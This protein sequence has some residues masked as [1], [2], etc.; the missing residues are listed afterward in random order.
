MGMG[1]WG[2]GPAGYTGLQAA[3]ASICGCEGGDTLR[4]RLEKGNNN[5]LC[6]QKLR[7]LCLEGGSLERVLMSVVLSVLL[8]SWVSAIRS[9]FGASAPTVGKSGAAL[10]KKYA[11]VEGN[12]GNCTGNQKRGTWS[13]LIPILQGSRERRG[14]SWWHFNCEKPA[15]CAPG[16]DPPLAP[17]SLLL[18]C[19][20]LAHT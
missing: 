16:W 11:L 18:A 4:H 6:C 14:D 9:P 19:S 8:S 20:F 13:G 2:D 15:S 12:R 3:A 10:A 17:V 7:F 1:G 5:T